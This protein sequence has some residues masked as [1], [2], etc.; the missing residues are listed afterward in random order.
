MVLLIENFFS[1][2]FDTTA[3]R[4]KLNMMANKGK[5]K[6]KEKEESEDYDR[7]VFVLLL[8]WDVWGIHICGRI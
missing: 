1:L 6:E 5:E 8:A 2:C 3:A 7:S 4:K